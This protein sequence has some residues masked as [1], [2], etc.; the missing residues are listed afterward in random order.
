MTH[1]QTPGLPFL[2]ALSSLAGMTDANAITLGGPFVSF[3]SGNT[4]RL[5]NTL[6]LHDWP[7]AEHL[8]WVLAG[9]T[10]GNTLGAIITTLNP[11]HPHR[12]LALITTLLAI[13]A[14]NSPTGA[15]YTELALMTLGMGALNATAIKTHGHSLGITY[16]SGALS[17]FGLALG[18]RLCGTPTPGWTLQLIPW[19]CLATGALLGAIL[20]HRLHAHALW[21]TAALA[22]I[23]TTHAS[24]CRASAPKKAPPRY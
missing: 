16:V 18:H 19:A 12:L 3:A 22:L 5:G 1:S 23:L 17:K 9:F 4:T 11:N 8:A 2:G 13:A 7:E 15:T 10:L 20:T 6:A 21:I 24:R 14:W